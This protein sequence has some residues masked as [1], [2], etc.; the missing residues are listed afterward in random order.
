MTTAARVLCLLAAGACLEAAERW[1]IEPPPSP[2]GSLAIRDLKFL[3]ATRGVGV[4][5]LGRGR[6]AR[7]VVILTSDGGKTWDTVETKEAGSSL[8]F[9][10]QETGWM[11][12]GN[13]LWK[14]ADSGRS[15]TRLPPSAA[16]EGISRVYFLD[17]RRGFA[18]GAHKAVYE[19]AN[20]GAKWQR[21][22][23][24]DQAE[25]SPEYTSFNWITFVNGRYGMIAGASVP[26]QPGKSGERRE[27]P[28]L[29]VFL[30]T[31]D[32]GATWTASTTS[33][34]GRVTRVVFAPDG[35][36]LG[37]IEFQR[38]FEFPA[39]VFRIDW[40]TGQSSRAF[41]QPDCAVTD[42]AF[43]AA[44]EAY[45]AGIQVKP[46]KRS[47][48][49]PGRLRVL[50]ST[51]LSSWSEMSVAP[52]AIARRAILSVLDAGHAWAATDEGKILRLA[53]E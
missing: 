47:G 9:L 25:S 48:D 24:A 42:I 19:T 20:G 38:D 16:T 4:G 34:F 13:G 2:G 29:T 18:V 50:R 39:E 5:L 41:R 21:V 8:F 53:P 43:G 33:M 28:H 45:L 22:A 6:R 36:G 30:D 46:E 40:K 44:G 51:D 11:V 23:A 27:L 37:L 1:R 12:T 31:R 26:P 7:P 35:R 52:R 32:G 14:T 15:W 3:S 17:E 10:N 49:A